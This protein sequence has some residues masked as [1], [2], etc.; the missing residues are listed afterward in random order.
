MK[1]RR[2]LALFWTVIYFGVFHIEVKA[3]DAVFS[4]FF[5]STLYLNPAL[6]GLDDDVTVNMS[7]RSQWRT[8]N[9]PYVTNQFSL[10][11]PYYK[12]KHLKPLGHM[13]GFGL[14]VYNDTAGENNNFKTTGVNGAFAYNLPLNQAYSSFISFG[15]QLGVINKRIDPDGLEWGEQYNPFIGFDAN[16][17]SSELQSRENR[18]FLDINSGV[19]WY[20]T[21]VKAQNTLIDVVNLGLSVSHLNNPDEALIIDERSQLPLLYKLHGSMIFNLSEKAS[22]SANFL[23][24]LQ[25]QEFQNNIGSYLSYKIGTVQSGT[26]KY[27]T[28]RAGAWHRIQDSF[29]FITEFET[30]LLKL[31]FSYDWNTST[32]RYNDR[33]IGTYE[34]FMALRFASKSVPKSRY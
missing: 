17:A 6:A 9:F 27:I 15:L 33:G 4:Q 21:P 7:H 14:S 24:A 30:Q 28:A 3:Q 23:T 12:D 29:I 8:L 19:F 5:N 22:I 10:I 34:L 20:H 2:L 11:I 26:F 18:T 32:L 16:I 13:G 31:G 1:R 25:D